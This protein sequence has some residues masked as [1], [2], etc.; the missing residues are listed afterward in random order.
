DATAVPASREDATISTPEVEY[1]FTFHGNAHEYFRIWIVNLALSIAT[2]GVFS[3][4]AKVRR[5]RYFY[6]NTWVAGAPFEYLADPIKILKGRVIAVSL[7]TAY[8]LFGQ[9]VPLA[10][11]ILALVVL[12]FVPWLLL[13]AL[14]FRARYSAWNTLTFRFAGRLSD[15]VRY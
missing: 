8:I 11:S 6:G 13:S 2:L 9:F 12:I 5:E 15:A 1:P 3:A 14:R 4:W 10:Q 7:M